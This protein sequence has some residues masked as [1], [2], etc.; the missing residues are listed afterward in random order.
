MSNERKDLTGLQFNNWKVIKYAGNRMWTCECQ[1]KRH[2]VKDIQDYSLTSGASKSCGKCGTAVIKVGDHFGEWEVIQADDKEIK[3]LCRCSCG[4]ERL[5]NK[6]TLLRGTSTGCGHT[7]NRDRVIDLTGQV[8]GELTVKE[9]L[10][11]QIWKCQ[12]SCGQFRTAH[13]NNLLDGRATSCG[14]E[15]D[16]GFIDIK[17]Q[18]FG[19]LVAVS[20]AGNKMWL[21]KCDC[22]NTK[23]VM[24][25]NLRN[26]S[27]KSCGCILNY[28]TEDEII[29]VINQFKEENGRAPFTNEL[30]EKLQA[31]YKSTEY[32]ITKYNL[33]S[34]LNNAGSSAMEREIAALFPNA[35]LG[36]RNV[37]PPYELDI[38]IPDRKLAIEFNGTFWHSSRNKYSKYHQ[39]KTIAC[40][41]KGIRL[42]HIFEYEW[43]NKD[44]KRKLI[45]M[46]V[47]EKT[48]MYA[49][50][51]MI[52]EVSIEEYRE[53]LEKN[54]LQGYAPSK[55]MLGCYDKS[56]KLL[57]VMGFGKPRF[58]DDYQY[59]II[60]LCWD[61]TVKVVGGAEKLF[62]YFVREYN[63][64]SVITYCDISKFTGN[65]YTRL[66]F[67][68]RQEKPI[69]E[70]NYV[71]V[72]NHNSD[73]IT[74]YQTQRSGLIRHGY[75]TEDQTED[76]IM[77]NLG[78]L[79]VFDCGNLVLVWTRE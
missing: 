79:K 23:L 47:G 18:R 28:F 2:T 12:C 38:Y 54:H 78:Y 24:G 65:V 11:N 22:G 77:H 49:R 60:R 64:K 69:T 62:K 44:T 16:K 32:F 5:V 55:I 52:R 40:A 1:C 4:K 6:Y 14:H 26:G 53:F 50:N 29:D 70:P 71:W 13:R 36:S 15:Y 27:T 72:G 63:P 67:N 20:Y 45:N 68:A 25:M 48:T 51:T 33:R 73:V 39:N 42:I 59:E 21:C 17:G 46:L 57:G 35:I 58:N 43:M 74:S 34:L 41:K 19:K 9:Y 30:A 7:K 3:V 61:S 10:G 56:D 8:F 66:G 31:T 37:I 76:E 75:G